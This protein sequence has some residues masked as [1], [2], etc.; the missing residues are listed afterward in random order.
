MVFPEDGTLV[1]YRKM[2]ELRFNIQM[3]LLQYISLV[4]YTE[5]IDPEQKFGTSVCRQS[6]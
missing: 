1:Q 5:Y 2:L 6:G 4:Q 3:H